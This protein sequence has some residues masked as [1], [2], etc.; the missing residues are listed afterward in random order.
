MRA[1]KSFEEFVRQNIV[2]K[3]SPDISRAEFLLK[4]ASNSY[5]NLLD[6]IEKL[7]LIESNANLF[8]KSCYDILME[9]ICAKMFLQGYNASGFGAHE[10]EVS[11]MRVL[12]FSENDVQFAEQL[13]FFRNGMLYYGTILDVPYA[14]EVLSFTKRV[15]FI[16]KK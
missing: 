6:M 14:Q 13:R 5:T 10:S 9:M 4:E 15:Y 2:K 11:Y 16:L 3:Q 7:P 12:L 1:I 8:I